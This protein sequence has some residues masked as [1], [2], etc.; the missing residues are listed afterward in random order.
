MQIFENA[1]FYNIDFKILANCSMFSLLYKMSI[2][3]GNMLR[4]IVLLACI[5]L[6]PISQSVAATSKKEALTFIA[7]LEATVQKSDAIL[8]SAENSKISDQSKKIADFRKKSEQLFVP[9]NSSIG[10]CQYAANSAQ[11]LWIQKLLIFQGSRLNKIIL[12]HAQEDYTTNLKFC[13]ESVSSL[14]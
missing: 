7:N 4:N 1:E 3:G 5:C 9:L 14:K 11:N 6:F 8:R 12:N 10:S 13:R 2:E